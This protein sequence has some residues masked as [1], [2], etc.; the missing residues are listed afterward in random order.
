MMEMAIF[1][2]ATFLL[3]QWVNNQHKLNLEAFPFPLKG[4][5][6][7][8]PPAERRFWTTLKE[9]VPP[10]HGFPITTH[11]DG[12]YSESVLPPSVALRRNP[13]AVSNVI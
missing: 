10:I 9:A 5:R 7:V 3:T 13:T 11:E 2:K 8:T 6:S 4:F 1:N 12:E